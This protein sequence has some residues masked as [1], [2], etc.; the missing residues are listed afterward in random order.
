MIG[1]KTQEIKV[2]G[3]TT[4]NVVMQDDTQALDEVVVIGYG[5]VKKGDLTSSIAAIKGDELK[6]LS[7]GNAMNSLQGKI[8]CRWSRYSSPRHHSRCVYSQWIQSVVCS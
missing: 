5:A 8:K 1:Y 6:T 7:S 3:R 4:I 2:N